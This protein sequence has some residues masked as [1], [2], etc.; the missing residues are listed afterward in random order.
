MGVFT[1]AAS[2]DRIMSGVTRHLTATWEEHP[3]RQTQQNP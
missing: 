2:V 3:L 1:N